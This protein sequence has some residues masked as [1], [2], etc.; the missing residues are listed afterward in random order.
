MACTRPP[1]ARWPLSHRS[2]GIHSIPFTCGM[3][4][5]KHIQ[6]HRARCYRP[7][8]IL[9]R[10]GSGISNRVRP[11]FPIRSYGPT[12]PRQ[13]SRMHAGCVLCRPVAG[14]AMRRPP[15]RLPSRLARPPCTAATGCQRARA[16]V[17]PAA[18][19]PAQGHG[20]T[21]P[22]RQQQ[23]ATPWG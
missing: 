8:M 23:P 7:C 14:R 4:H 16:A 22:A 5:L 13:A 11:R 21:L 1:T 6:R 2:Q 12:Q 3:V 15:S 17:S 9:T 10:K 18:S 19:Q 20:C